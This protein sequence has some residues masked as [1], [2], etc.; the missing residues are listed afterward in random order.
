MRHDQIRATLTLLLVLLA[1]WAALASPAGAALRAS[2]VCATQPRDRT[3]DLVRQAQH[4]RR[5][6]LHYAWCLGWAGHTP[7]VAQRIV[8][9][10]SD[11]ERTALESHVA[12]L[13]GYCCRA[14]RR[15]RYPHV[16]SAFSWRPCVRYYWPASQVEKCLRTIRRESGGNPR[17]V[18]P[19]SGAAGL[20]Q[21]L[22]S[23]WRGKWDAF[24]GWVNIKMGAALYRSSG[25]APWAGGA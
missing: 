24:V 9:P 16:T 15:I 19:S 4:W 8:E 13:H 10:A 6:A 25:W 12:F 17:A 5:A 11:A 2:P 14:L 21:F 22:P 20:L 23:W 1:L 3:A 7:R 18:N